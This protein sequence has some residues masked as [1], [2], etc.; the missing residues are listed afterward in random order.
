MLINKKRTFQQVNFAVS[1]DRRVKIKESEK[2]EEYLDLVRK[3]KKQ[4]NT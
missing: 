4:W 1:T 2:I 3:L